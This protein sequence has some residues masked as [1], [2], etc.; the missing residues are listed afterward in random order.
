MAKDVNINFKP[1]S[2]EKQNIEQVC[3]EIDPFYSDSNIRHLEN[4]VRDI[5]DDKAHFT[6]HDLIEVDE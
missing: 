6:E 1:D 4:I 5:K 3:S 2:D